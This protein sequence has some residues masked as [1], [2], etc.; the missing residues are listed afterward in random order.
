MVQSYV[1]W[2]LLGM[3]G[4]S[5]MT[6]FVKLAERSGAASTHMVLA[7]T[8]TIVP[9]FAIAVVALRGELKPL[10]LELERPPL[11]WAIAG[12]IALTIAVNALFHAL[13]LGPANVVVPI[14]GMF[15]VGGSLLSVLFLG[16]PMTWNKIAG[17]VAAVIGV[18]LIA[19]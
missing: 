14:Y 7:V 12:G 16:E 5:L 6:L 4:Y 13:S 3:A 2:A 11:L 19:L 15:I 8:T 1:L 10:L 18:I 9:I 17:L